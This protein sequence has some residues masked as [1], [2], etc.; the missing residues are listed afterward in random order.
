M[1]GKRFYQPVLLEKHVR[2]LYRLK[3]RT[4]LPMTHH[5]RLAVEQYVDRWGEPGEKAEISRRDRRMD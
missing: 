5:A 3:E 4:G 1:E 2:A